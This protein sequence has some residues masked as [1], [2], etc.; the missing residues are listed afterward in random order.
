MLGKL[1]HVVPDGR[2]VQL[3]KMAD[4]QGLGGSHDEPSG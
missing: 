2:V 1:L 4:D 3:S